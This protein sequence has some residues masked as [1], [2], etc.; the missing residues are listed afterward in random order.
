MIRHSKLSSSQLK[1]EVSEIQLFYKTR[2][3]ASD[4]PQI[5]SSQEAHQILRNCSDENTIE[6]KEEFKILLINRENKVLGQM[7]ISSGTTSGA[8]IDI[9]F[10]VLVASRTN[11]SGAILSHNHPSGNLKPSHAD[12][13]L[14]HK[15]KDV[16]NLIDV[17]V[18]D[19]IIVTCDSYTSLADEGSI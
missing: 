6:L 17:C 18:L 19:H 8:L 14:T 3:K 16:L 2:T 12:I 13:K 4:R 11:A 9:K 5:N 1:F 15:I 10:I 7:N